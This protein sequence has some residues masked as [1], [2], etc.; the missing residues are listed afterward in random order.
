MASPQNPVIAFL[1]DIQCAGGASLTVLKALMT[2]GLSR[3]I[4]VNGAYCDNGCKPA[5]DPKTRIEG[6]S[7]PRTIDLY[8][9]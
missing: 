7:S 4:I 2:D 9:R 8:T 6:V 3:H 1:D 5:V